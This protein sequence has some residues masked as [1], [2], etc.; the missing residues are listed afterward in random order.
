MCA[1]QIPTIQSN[2]NEPNESP[3][4]T[5]RFAPSPTGALHL[6]NARTF[7]INWAL[8]RQ[9]GERIVFRIED[10]DGPRVKPGADVQAIE[11]MR[12]LGL[13]WDEEPLYQRQDLSRYQVAINRL[14]EKGLVYPCQCTRKDIEAAQSAPNAGDHEM[15]Y[16]GICRDLEGGLKPELGDESDE[17]VGALGGV[18]WRLR[19]PE[20]EISF[21]DELRGEVRVDVQKGVGDFVIATKL[22]LPAYQLAVV[23]DDAMQ[24]VTHVVRGHDLLQSTGRQLWLYKFLE[25]EPPTRYTHLPL[26]AGE[27]GRRLAKRHGDTRVDH[28][29]QSGVR[30]ERIIGLLAYWS[31]AIERR[32][33]MSAVE[34][35]EA[36]D[37]MKMSREEMVFGPRDHAWLMAGTL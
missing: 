29:R 32:Q 25:L 12:W 28:Y 8:A 19:V 16:P 26:I 4:P 35:L 6:G 11:T 20:G 5:T 13:D 14:Y 2:Q 23:L 7:L 21:I 31:G 27:D 17:R 9:G 18:A 24:G 34:F 36:F 22:G 33:E 37:L 1:D 10:L 15:R 3:S 30:S